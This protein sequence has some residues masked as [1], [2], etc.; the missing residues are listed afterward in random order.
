MA[1]K[2]GNTCGVATAAAAFAL[3]PLLLAG[4]STGP[5]GAMRFTLFPASNTLMDSTYA[6][7]QP[8]LP[9]APVPREM[10]QRVL[11]PYTVEPGDSVIVYPADLDSPVRLPGDQVIMPDGTISLG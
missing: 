6:V 10:D 5:G 1:G 11:A 4:F 8:V 2:P 3:A 7:R 9:P